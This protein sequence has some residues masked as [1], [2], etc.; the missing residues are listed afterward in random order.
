MIIAKEVAIVLAIVWYIKVEL[1]RCKQL[2]SYITY[3]NM[4]L[5]PKIKADIQKQAF[6]VY[7]NI[8]TEK[9]AIATLFP[10]LHGL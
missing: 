5:V 9:V 3:T 10:G 6:L 2:P 4:D 7:S 1:L 8:Y